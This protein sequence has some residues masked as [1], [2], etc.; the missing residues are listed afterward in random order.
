MWVLV[1]AGAA[2]AA[3]SYVAELWWHPYGRCWA[4]G[5]SGWNRWS[6]KKRY[7]K[8]RRCKGK[9]ERVRVGARLVRPGLRKGK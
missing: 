4:C 3:G 1:A 9:R 7:G 5:G 6:S 8:C 2:I